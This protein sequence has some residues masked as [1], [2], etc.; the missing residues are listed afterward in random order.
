MRNNGKGSLTNHA[1]PTLFRSL[2]DST[3]DESTIIGLQR[4]ES[5]PSTGSRLIRGSAQLVD[6]S[7]ALYVLTT[8]LP[9]TRLQHMN[10]IGM[11]VSIMSLMLL[12]S[13]CT[14]I[15]IPRRAMSAAWEGMR[16]MY[17]FSGI[18]CSLI[19]INYLTG[20]S[21]S[22]QRHFNGLRWNHFVPLVFC[23]IS[24]LHSL[25]IRATGRSSTAEYAPHEDFGDLVFRDETTR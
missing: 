11:T 18:I 12:I 19:F 2:D 6:F 22:S 7:L 23:I 16:G 8:Q 5:Q 9:L 14:S 15:V 3:T 21:S 4:G 1:K 20:A 17:Y 13:V 25:A 24:L 10:H